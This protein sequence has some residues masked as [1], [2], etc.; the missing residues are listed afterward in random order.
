[1]KKDGYYI[2]TSDW[3]TKPIFHELEGLIDIIG[4]RE[5]RRFIQQ[6]REGKADQW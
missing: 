5:K 1:M 3:K 4:L 2:P 6:I